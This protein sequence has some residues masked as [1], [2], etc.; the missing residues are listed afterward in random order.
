MSTAKSDY[1]DNQPRSIGFSLDY[2]DQTADPHEDFYRYAV[3]EWLKT[4][5]VPPDKSRWAAFNELYDRNL[6]LL[7]TI[8]EEAAE[9]ASAPV[10]SPKRLI[11]DF[12]RSAMD[13]KRIQ[14]LRFEPILPLLHKID[15]LE[16]GDG[17]VRFLGELQTS[18]IQAFFSSYSD[19][20]K[21]NSDI[22]AFYLDQGGL[23]L[24]DRD[25]YLSDAFARLR[26]SYL[27]HVERMFTLAGESKE[28]SKNRAATV[29]RMETELAKTS[30][31]R[32]ELRDDE[33]NYNRMLV[34]ELDKSFPTLSLSTFLN[35]ASVSAS[36]YVV[37]GQPEFFGRLDGLLSSEPIENIRT[38]LRWV[39][40]HG[41]APFLHSEVD[42]EDFSFFHKE[43]LGQ[44]EPEARWKR[45]TKII[46]ALLGEA[47]GALYVERHFPPEAKERAGQMIDDIREVFKS[48][49]AS[50]P[51]MTESTRK[52]ALDKFS[53][54]RTKIGYP[55]KFRDYSSI[56][57]D[58]QDLVGNVV[59]CA[60]FES[61]RQARRVG[62][63]VDRSEWLMSPP[64]VNAYF[65]PV[66]NTINFP[67]GILQ[68]PFFDMTQDDA[69]NY[70]GI[71]M[72]IGHEITHG[73]DDQGRKFDADGNLHD[74][75]T[76]EDADEFQKRARAVVDLYNALEPL[77][78]S[79]V[80][81]ELTL[82]ENI[83][84]FGGLSLA[85]EALQRRL[86]KEPAKRKDI[87]GL[88]PEQRFFLSYGQIWRENVREQEVRRLLTIDPHSPGRYRA[89]LPAINHPEF[90]V[91]FPQ[92][93][94][95]KERKQKVAVW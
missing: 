84:D 44:E 83:A 32:T 8:L 14:E 62:Q 30:R 37:I 4:N 42:A 79:H 66:E 41:F 61:M 89:T 13:T 51:W 50:L 5:P 73:Y 71:G 23:S 80:N 53:R 2:M 57:T 21:K 1:R 25:Y 34:N 65:N 31:S 81:G 3:G 68:P 26:E 91:A 72:V 90:D 58:P 94:G 49:L 6:L 45:T 7:K 59:R 33:K 24:P 56:R 9:D 77:P 18:G 69:V 55:D 60:A 74:W 95:Q 87:D 46:D 19:A 11:G 88:K 38:Y 64:T 43:L 63:K 92:N 35:V 15:R 82:G 52:L 10:G 47:L 67:A 76:K 27:A 40:L 86:S 39:V 78:G 20:D 28:G 12:Y 22:Y 54:F 85:F 29:L 48:R 93:N 75:W 17:L 16:R 70:G 36:D